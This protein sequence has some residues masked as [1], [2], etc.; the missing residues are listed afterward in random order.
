MWIIV[1]LYFARRLSNQGS[2]ECPSRRLRGSAG[3]VSAKIINGEEV[4]PYDVFVLGQ[5]R[6]V[7]PG[8]I[9]TARRGNVR[10]GSDGR[11]NVGASYEGEHRAR[12]KAE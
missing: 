7:I 4:V 12:N 2:G 3:N 6:A 5:S 9:S 10:R 1:R 11:D 8:K